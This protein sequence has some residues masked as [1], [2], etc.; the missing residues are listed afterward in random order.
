MRAKDRDHRSTRRLEI[1]LECRVRI[2]VAPLLGILLSAGTTQGQDALARGERLLESKDYAAAEAAL[3]EA[4]AADPSSAR[5]HGKLA[6]ALLAQ[7]RLPEAVEEGRL[8]A[9]LEPGNPE[10]RQIYALALAMSGRALEAARELEAVV[11]AKPDE[12]DP[13]R[14]LAAAYSEAQ[15]DRAV[16]AFE[17]LVKLKPE[18]P[19][20]RIRLAEHHWTMGDTERGNQVLEDAL[21]AL[22]G[23]SSLHARYGRALFGQERVVDAARELERA[24]DTGATDLPTLSLL[25]KALSRAGETEAAVA[26]F[27]ATLKQ[28]PEAGSVHEDF[29]RLLLSLGRPEPA[30]VSLQESVRLRP[31]Q[32]SA[33]LELGRAYEALGKVAE[34]EQAYRKAMSL[35]PQLVA[36]H[37]ALGSLLT[38]HG[39]RE[40]GKREL[41]LYRTFYDRAVRRSQEARARSGEIAFGWAELRQ[42]HAETALARFE[43]IPESAETLIG[44]ASA[45]SRL[46]RHR[47][48]VRVLERARELEPQSPLVQNLLASERVRA[49][50]K[51]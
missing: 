13:L 18:A 19:E 33:H 14:G 23:L 35:G 28:Y 7:R 38:R 50:E 37:Y 20:Y 46:G 42:G 15:D 29:G 22:P 11:A 47:D 41:A 44:Q 8:A 45:L 51:P 48:A 9:T 5:A 43:A 26:A 24:R 32:P 6:L 21:R 31:D 25:C 49:E 34:A 12:L 10:A 27:T 16:A 40:E 3:R 2:A 4:T 1:G 39:D 36:P 17:K 30:L